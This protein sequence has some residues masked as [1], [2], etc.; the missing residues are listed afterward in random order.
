MYDGSSGVALFLAVLAKITGNSQWYDLALGTLQPLR[1]AFQDSRPD[2]VARLTRQLG[3]SGAIGLGSIAYALAQISQL[4]QEPAL[5]QDALFA[6]SLITPNLIAADQTFDV[7]GGTA[8][9]ILGL[10][11]LHNIPDS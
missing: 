5:L 3:I 1:Y 11:V 6:T 7:M 8:G 4:L 2:F 9:A 10:L